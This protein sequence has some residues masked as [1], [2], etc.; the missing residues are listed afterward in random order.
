MYDEQ[1]RDLLAYVGNGMVF[2]IPK[3]DGAEFY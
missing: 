2:V 1:Y 3:H